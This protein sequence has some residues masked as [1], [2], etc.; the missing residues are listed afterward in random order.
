MWNKPI[1]AQHK[2]VFLSGATGAPFVIAISGG[3]LSER[4]SPNGRFSQAAPE[5]NDA[6]YNAFVLSY[7]VRGRAVLMPRPSDR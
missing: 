5:L 6:G 1:A 3:G 4:L 2:A 7:R